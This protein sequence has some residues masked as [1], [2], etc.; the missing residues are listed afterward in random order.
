MQLGPYKKPFLYALAVHLAVILVLSINL[1][2]SPKSFTAP[3]SAGE[4][5]VVQAK[6][7][8]EA[9]V[10]KE[11]DKL[12]AAERRKK[13][14]EAARQKAL[15][16]K[17]KAAERKRLAEE[18]RLA[19]LKKDREAQAKEQAQE[20]KRLADLKKKKQQ[21]AERLA[22]LQEE[23]RKAEDEKRRE[24]EAEAR[25]KQ[26]AEEEKRLKAEQAKVEAATRARN[27][28]ESLKYIAQMQAKVER[29]WNNPLSGQDGLE[30]VV[31][32]RLNPQ[33][34]VLLAQV[35]KSS[36]NPV[37]DRS[38]ET[39]VLKASPLPLPKDPSIMDGFPE[40]RFKFNPVQK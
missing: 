32:V 26:I 36:G 12:R 5:P 4:Q 7:V 40:L 1:H 22:K 15:E 37:F 24:A 39:A 31:R 35:V 33:G 14:R 27:Q 19:K 9:E 10:K 38:V 6:A 8:D 20:A 23:A 30:C 21:E 13:A 18:K 34:V 25:Q 28:A 3:P 17:A 16:N 11:M 2:F 29:N